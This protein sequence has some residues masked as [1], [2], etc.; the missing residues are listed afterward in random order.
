MSILTSYAI[1]KPLPIVEANMVKIE[2]HTETLDPEILR[3]MCSELICERYEI[4]VKKGLI[5]ST[6][7]I[8]LD[9]CRLAR[10]ES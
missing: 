9:G 8:R 5:N 7:V 3:F 6:T 1:R 2:R 4:V 10:K